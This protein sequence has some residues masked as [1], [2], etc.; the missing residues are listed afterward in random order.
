M[1]FYFPLLAAALLLTACNDE[2]QKAAEHANQDTVPA[3]D[4]R[5]DAD[6]TSN[7]VDTNKELKTDTPVKR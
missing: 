7:A 2:V 6:S 4:T 5:K 1:K 3:I